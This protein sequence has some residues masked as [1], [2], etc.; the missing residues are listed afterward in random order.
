MI[1]SL[2]TLL[3]RHRHLLLILTLTW[4]TVIFLLSAQSSIHIPN[5]FFMQDK[6]L[7]SLLFGA[8]GFFCSLLV[9]G[10]GSRP[11]FRHVLVVTLLVMGYGGLD[12][13]HQ[14]FVPGRSPDILD[15]TADTTG[16]FII[17]LVMRYILGRY[18]RRGPLI[19]TNHQ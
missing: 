12:E 7:H 5:M 14:S 19:L 17:A 10:D 18:A 1:N 11:T 16:G 9:M 6:A 3:L 15:L 8:L 4:M 13:F 2:L